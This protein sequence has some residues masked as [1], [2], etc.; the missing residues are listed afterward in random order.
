MVLASAT[1]AKVFSFEFNSEFK[2]NYF[3]KILRGLCISYRSRILRTYI[4]V[5]FLCV[6]NMSMHYN[7]NIRT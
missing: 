6:Y 4:F 5:G 1:I 2:Q 3:V 7:I